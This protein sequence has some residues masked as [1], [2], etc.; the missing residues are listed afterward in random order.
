MAFLLSI[1]L[2]LLLIKMRSNY[3]DRDDYCWKV[4]SRARPKIEKNIARTGKIYREV[5]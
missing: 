4:N 2:A 3:K 1:L 5:S